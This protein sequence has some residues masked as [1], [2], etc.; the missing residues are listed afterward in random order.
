MTDANGDHV[1]PLPVLWPGLVGI[2]LAIQGR[3]C[4]PNLQTPG[5]SF[6]APDFFSNTL[7]VTFGCPPT[8]PTWRHLI[9]RTGAR[10]LRGAVD[11]GAGAERSAPA[12]FGGR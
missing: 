4:A 12:A 11:A 6:P 3:V 8:N 5:P 7:I 2:R 1:Q 10:A 9:E